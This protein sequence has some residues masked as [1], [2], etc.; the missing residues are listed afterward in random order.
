MTDRK[1]LETNYIQRQ[2]ELAQAQERFAKLQNENNDKKKL[3]DRTE[4]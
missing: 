1:T 2:K 3:W 4:D